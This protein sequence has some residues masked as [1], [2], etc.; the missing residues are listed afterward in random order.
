MCTIPSLSFVQVSKTKQNK[1]TQLWSSLLFDSFFLVRV[2]AFAMRAVLA[3][4]ESTAEN[5]NVV[6]A[7]EALF[8]IGYFG[9]I[10]SAY[11]LVLDR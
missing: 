6:I 1:K 7:D 2:V 10:Y 5:L 11:N 8:S 3:G 4:S 9:L